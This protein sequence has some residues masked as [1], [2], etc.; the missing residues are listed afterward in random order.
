MARKKRGRR[1]DVNKKQ[2]VVDALAADEFAEA[3]REPR[4]V[5]RLFGNQSGRRRVE[6]TG[7]RLP[8]HLPA[9]RQLARGRG[10]PN[11]MSRGIR[12][13]E[14]LVVTALR[15]PVQS[16]AADLCEEQLREGWRCGRRLWQCR[17]RLC[18]RRS[19]LDCAPIT[20]G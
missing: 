1:G 16:G 5:D 18:R 17:R 3:D 13:V 8:R 14:W 7:K 10:F 11:E 19:G 6:R 9:P 15:R 20:E 12:S 2:L 4:G